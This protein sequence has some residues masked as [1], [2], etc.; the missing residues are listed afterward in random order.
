VAENTTY[1]KNQE[2]IIEL[3]EQEDKIK[4]EIAKTAKEI[5]D[6]GE[7]ATKQQ[8]EQLRT[9]K[10]ELEQKKAEKK[11]TAEIGSI[12]ESMEDTM[13]K[14]ALLSF[15]ILKNEKKLKDVAEQI[16]SNKANLGKAERKR[17]D[18]NLKAAK[19]EFESAK[20]AATEM[21]AKQMVSEKLQDSLGVSANSMREL[22]AQ[23]ILFG[24]AVMKNPMILLGAALVGAGMLLKKAITSTREFQKELGLSAHQA[25]ELNKEL[26]LNPKLVATAKLAGI[27]LNDVAAKIQENFGDL[28]Q[29]NAKNIEQLV[30]QNLLL[31]IQIDSSVK[32]A[33]TF[34][35][36]T[37]S[38]FE[39]AMNFQASTAAL[40]ESNDVAPGDVIADIAENSESFAEFAKDGGNNIARAAIQAKKL[41]INLATTAKIADTLLDFESSIEKEM[42]ASLLIGKQLNFNNARRLALEGDLAGAARDVVSQIG[43]QAE[44]N[45]MNVIQ[46][47]ALADSIGVSVEELSKLASGKLEVKNKDKSIDERNLEARKTIASTQEKLIQATDALKKATIALAAIM[48]VNAL[49][50]LP[51][52]LKNLTPKLETMKS[53][54]QRFTKKVTP[55]MTKAG[56]LSKREGLGRTLKDSTRNL[57]ATSKNL[58]K[59]IVSKA[60]KALVKGGVVG[61]AVGG[62]DIVSGIQNQDKGAIGGGAGAIIGGAIGSFIA[63]GFGTVVG[64]V[65]GQMIGEAIGSKLEASESIEDKQAEINEVKRK[66]EEE[67]AK[68]SADDRKALLIAQAKGGDALQKFIDDNDSYFGT[69]GNSLDNV[70]EL[71]KTLNK[72]QDDLKNAV[73]ELPDN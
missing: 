8:K 4:K 64:S 41:G 35:D 59:S 51:K 62:A 19:A 61:A 21:Q 58:T 22:K 53:S 45:R 29:V 18:N 48:G 3:T 9:Q 33:K 6:A 38:S 66:L 57:K 17:L 40:A 60:P 30:E 27:E 23:A 47:R 26:K 7:K 52:T 16:K 49:M 70:A 25:V 37:G 14:E 28:N 34:M 36:V 39:T 50:K 55:K 32:L 10:I 1:L 24:R 54:A 2:K 42:E 15:D 12:H 67:K 68:L 20:D 73:R 56:N 65:A 63:P 31:G 69:F 13:D 44:L 11:I 72:K 71:L 5:A 46:R 43:G